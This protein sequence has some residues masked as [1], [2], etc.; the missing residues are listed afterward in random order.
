MKRTRS[1]VV[2]AALLGLLAVTPT[3][4]GAF[5][6]ANGHIAYV[7]ASFSDSEDGL[8]SSRSQVSLIAGALRGGDRLTLRSC[9]KIA[10]VPRDRDCATSFGT[11]AYSPDGRLLAVDAGT[12]LAILASDGSNFSLL[13][14]Q[15]ADDG[16]P[17]WS[18]DGRR[19]AFTGTATGATSPDLHVLSVPNGTS[20]RL[21]M[22]GARSPAWSSRNRIAYVARYS[23]PAGRPPGGQLATINPDGSGRRLL[24]RRG[25]LAPAW[26]PHA[27]R[28]AFVRQGRL[29]VMLASGKRVWRVGG[30]RPISADDV[31]WS[32]DGR[33]LAFHAFES[34][35]LTV[36][37]DGTGERQFADAARSATAGHDSFSPDWGPVPRRR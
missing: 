24:T 32:P 19:I 23:S 22:A 28:I 33:L 35:I 12:Q 15:T 1:P 13:P 3:A 36:Q 26:S 18:P 17:A 14:R 20:R 29:H 6:G 11:P 5:P 16:E 30:R 7:R 8:G 10:D 21:T 34:G 27:T 25:G 4:Q 37:A 31:A 9:T 2:I